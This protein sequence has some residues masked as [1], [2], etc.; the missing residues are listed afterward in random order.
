[1]KADTG[2]QSPVHIPIC[3]ANQSEHFFLD[4]IMLKP[5]MVGKDI[6][7]AFTDL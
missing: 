1:M 7:A 4:L 5:A 3:Y 2:T 6:M